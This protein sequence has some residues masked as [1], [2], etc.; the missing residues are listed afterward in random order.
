MFRRTFSRPAAVALMVLCTL[1][2]S[3]AGVLTRHLEAATGFEVTFWRSAFCAPVVLALL[4]ATGGR[5]ALGALRRPSRDLLASGL[6]WATMFSCFMLAL[7]LTSTSNTL[8][9]SSVAPLVTAVL[10][11]IVLHERVAARTWGAITLAVAG[12]AWI[13][14]GGVAAGSQRD[15]LG[16]AVAFM[17][18]LASGTN[19]VQFKRAGHQV[20]LVPAVCLGAVFSALA[21]L[22]FALPFQATAQDLAILF[23]L[24]A[25][26]LA[27]PCM[28][29][30][31]AAR[32]LA[33]PQIALLALLEA[34]FGPLWAWL[35]AGE[36]PSAATLQ[37]GSVVILALV[38]HE[39]L[40][41]ARRRA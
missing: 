9:M 18:P 24:G 23:V 31:V 32:S 2:W 33:A 25:F 22:P 27:L 6:L 21:M 4:A 39:C 15:L 30:V 11:W 13:F 29:M 37:G 19:M 3:I 1:L 16:M 34:V 17:V 36:T 8:V 38:L 26:Q 12:M 28:L 40:D 35:G 41:L 7:T 10:A 5:E 20:D 14:A